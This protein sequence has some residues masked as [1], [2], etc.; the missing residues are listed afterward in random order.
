MKI[1]VTKF[2]NIGDVLL[3]TPVFRSLRLTYPDAEIHGA[4]N[5]Y[6]A[7]IL[8]DNPDI[9]KVISYQRLSGRQGIFAR[10]A[11]EWAFYKQFY[12]QYDMVINLTEGDRGC[13]IAAVSGADLRM[14]YVKKKAF[15]NR[16]ASYQL[17]FPTESTLHTVEKDLQFM[18]G[19]EGGKVSAK[20]TMGWGKVDEEYVNQQMSDLQLKKGFVVVHPVSRWMFKCWEPERM[21]VVID[22]IQKKANKQVLLT[23]SPDSVEMEMAEKIVSLC[24]QKPLMLPKPLSLQAYGCLV[25]QASMYFGIDSAPMHIAAAVDTPVVALFGASQPEFW[26]P[27]DNNTGAGYKLVDGTQTKGRHTAIVNT[28]HAI[29]YEAGVKKSRGMQAI[30]SEQVLKVL[31]D[32]FAIN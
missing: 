30:S 26:G 22:F 7:D 18:Q 27:W 5:H 12:R 17:F 13:L 2:R 9:D 25:S 4:V 32:K 23:V 8:N 6:C 21:A 10:L 15:I 14:G 20:V 11:S 24:D 3:S 28:D 1:L 19:I 16:L 31:T 29:F